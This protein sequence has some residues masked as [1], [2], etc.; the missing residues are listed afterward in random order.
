MIED[1]IHSFYVIPH[2]TKKATQEIPLEVIYN[3]DIFDN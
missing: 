2:K 1:P 3:F